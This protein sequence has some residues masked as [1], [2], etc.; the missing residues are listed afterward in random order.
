[1]TIAGGGSVGE[2]RF[3]LLVQNFLDLTVVPDEACIQTGIYGP[4]VAILGHRT[5]ELVRAP[6]AVISSAPGCPGRGG[7]GAAD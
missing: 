4:L 3:R 6:G 5:D 7:A 1:M 2:D